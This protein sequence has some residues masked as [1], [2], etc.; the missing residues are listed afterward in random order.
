[1]TCR[2][3]TSE[4]SWSLLDPKPIIKYVE[5][6]DEYIVYWNGVVMSHLMALNFAME[7]YSIFATPHMK[8]K[9]TLNYEKIYHA[10]GFGHRDWDSIVHPSSEIYNYH[11]GET[12]K[13]AEEKGRS[14]GSYSKVYRY[15]NRLMYP[16]IK[17]LSKN[18]TCAEMLGL[19]NYDRA[20]R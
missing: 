12:T 6:C 1:M 18:I 11:T 15:L 19:F 8:K 14:A 2:T 20:R 16:H 5:N 9:I 17:E 4:Y 7:S 10:N 13:L 3:K